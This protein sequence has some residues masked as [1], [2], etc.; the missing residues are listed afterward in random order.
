MGM[1]IDI[2]FPG[3]EAPPIPV[4]AITRLVPITGEADPDTVVA[5]CLVLILVPL[6]LTTAQVAR[7]QIWLKRASQAAAPWAGQRGYALEDVSFEGSE[8]NVAIEGSGP[9]PPGSQLLARLRGQLPAGTPV[10]V[11]ST[12]G[13]MQPIGHVPG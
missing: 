3:D 6:T 12:T 2:A 5:F 7:E 9:P 4:G 11:N 13:G 1:K 10:V 8:L